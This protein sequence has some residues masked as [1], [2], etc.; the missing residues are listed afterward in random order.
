MSFEERQEA[1]E[2]QQCDPDMPNL[3]VGD[4]NLTDKN[5]AQFKKK[6]PMFV[7]GMSDSN[8]ALCCTSETFLKA[9]RDD[10]QAGHY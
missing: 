10:F 6:N 8:C 4:M 7:L 9:L 3:A 2:K 5:Y 1:M